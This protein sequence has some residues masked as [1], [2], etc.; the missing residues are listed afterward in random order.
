VLN[1]K[2]NRY[3]LTVSWPGESGKY[4]AASQTLSFNLN[5]K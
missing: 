3:T 4:D 2:P 5:K 1:Q